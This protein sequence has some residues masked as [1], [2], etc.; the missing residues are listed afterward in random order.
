MLWQFVEKLGRFIRVFR[1]GSRLLF[2]YLKRLDW[3]RRAGDRKIL[4]FDEFLTLLSFGMSYCLFRRYL[5]DAIVSA[6]SVNWTEGEFR[7]FLES[8]SEIFESIIRRLTRYIL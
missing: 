3:W 7:V 2:V 1:I 4:V 6:S 5:L 8:E